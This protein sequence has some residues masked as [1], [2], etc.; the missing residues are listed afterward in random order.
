MGQLMLCSFINAPKGFVSCNGQLLAI[1]QNQALFSLLGTTYG[2]DGRVNFGLPD[3]RGRIPI[4]FGQGFTQGQSGGQDAH[5]LTI[6]EAPAH[7]HQLQATTTNGAATKP[8]GNMLANTSGNLTIYTPAANLVAM[9]PGSITSVGG[10]QRH[11]NRQPFLT[12]NWVIAL[13]GIF[14]SRN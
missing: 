14:P 6:S 7:S 12:M 2:G 5:T 8:N 3:L 1:N 11:E 13:Q 9:N 10:S 4:S